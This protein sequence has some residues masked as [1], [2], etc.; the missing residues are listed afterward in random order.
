M[1]KQ[2]DGIRD[3]GAVIWKGAFQEVHTGWEI[4]FDNNLTVHQH[5]DIANKNEP[6]QASNSLN[7]PYA[8]VKSVLGAQIE[9]ED[10]QTRAR[11]KGSRQYD[12]SL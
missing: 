3:L 8:L 12:E 7:L 9:R 2:A 11:V 5:C 10:W 1:G 4:L 6:A